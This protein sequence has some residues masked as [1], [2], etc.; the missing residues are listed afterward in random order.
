VAQAL[1][2]Q[3]ASTENP[4]KDA[5]IN[6]A[7]GVPQVEP[8]S[9]GRGINYAKSLEPLPGVL[10]RTDDRT[11]QAIYEDQPAKITTEQ[12]TN[13]G[14][15]EVIGEFTT[16]GFAQD[17]GLNIRRVAEQVN[18]ALVKPG[19]TFSLNGLTGP[20][21]AAQGYVEAGVIEH[22]APSRA[23][24]GGISQFATTLFNATY[25]A[26]LQDVYHKEHSYYISRYPAGREATVFD[27]LIDLR[28]RNDAKTGLTVQTVWS[29]SN[30]T[31]RIWGTKRYTVEGQT[32]PRS[33]PTEPN[34]ITKAPGETCTP[35][36]GAPGFTVTDTRILR[37]VNTGAEVRRDNRTVHYN[38][39]PKVVCAT[40]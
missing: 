7:G 39:Q 29:P 22:G 13:M 32:G 14:I 31:I 40:S 17:S 20:R 37:D 24:G 8:S 38:P 15:K 16:G 11:I 26:G 35:A 19:D 34:I 2:P 18:G 6:L 21:T 27:G 3:L 28:F 36:N 5:K 9:D 33:N 25:N 12:A 23:V 1:K 4:G 30:I 10:V